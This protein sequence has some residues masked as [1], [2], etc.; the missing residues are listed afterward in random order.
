MDSGCGSSKFTVQ[1][2]VVQRNSHTSMKRDRSFVD[3][4][5]CGGN[6]TNK[7]PDIISE[8][9]ILYYI[10]LAYYKAGRQEAP[11]DKYKQE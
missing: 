5:G 11:L 1:T 6:I 10:W 2:V 7:K 3:S 4:R 9:Y 8:K